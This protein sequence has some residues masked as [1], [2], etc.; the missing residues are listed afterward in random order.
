MCFIGFHID[1]YA[2]K[3]SIRVI[4]DHI[5]TSKDRWEMVL[6]D[7]CE[8]DYLKNEAPFWKKEIYLDGS[9]VWVAQKETD[10]SAYSHWQ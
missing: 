9:E 7:G 2:Y 3:E 1:E 8:M 10:Q 4:E 5:E 6:G